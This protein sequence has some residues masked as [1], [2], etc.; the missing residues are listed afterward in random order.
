MMCIVH[1]TA[2]ITPF[3][4][5]EFLRM[6]FGLRNA[7][8]TFQRMMDEVMSELSCCF[9]YLD[10]MLLSS[11]EH[12]QHVQHLKEVVARL[13]LHGLVLN[14]EKC[15]FGVSTIEYLGCSISASGIRPL[16]TRLTTFQRFQ[17]PKTVAQLQTYLEMV[18]FYRKCSPVPSHR[19]HARRAERGPGLDGGD[20]VIFRA[21]QVAL[22]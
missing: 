10:D 7:G 21:Q 4:L 5:Y 2:I 11:V 15:Q 20:A 19:G 16:E 3:G 18:N 1:K 12:V 6:P 8:Q 14:A 22:C 17:R 13:Q 9:V